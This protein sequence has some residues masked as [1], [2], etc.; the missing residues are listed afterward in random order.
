MSD[1]LE[2]LQ[3]SVSPASDGFDCIVPSFRPD[4]VKEVDLV[5][6]V[7]RIVG[8][9][10]MPETLPHFASAGGDCA[11]GKF[12]SA[13]RRLFI[14]QGMNEAHSHTLGAVSAFDDPELEPYRVKL[15]SALS[16][17][18]SVLRLSLVPGLLI[19][20]ASNLRRHETD[21]RLFELGK[22]YRT[23][24][25]QKY[26][27]PR[28]AAGALTGVGIDFFTAK[29]VIE[30]ALTALHVKDV[31]FTR[32]ALHGCHP[33]RCASIS[34]NGS[35]IGF[36][37]EIDPD[38]AKLHLDLPSSASRIAVF[39]IDADAL[40]QEAAKI[41]EVIYIAPPKFP[42]VSRDL[43]LTYRVETLYGEIEQTARTAVGEFLES[44][45]L[46]SVY[47]GDKMPE[48]F[49]SVAIR[50]TLRAE[51]RTLTDA[52]ADSVLSNV[53]EALTNRLGGAVR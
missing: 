12:E 52:D 34:V 26:S 13:L 42:A 14:A 32:S 8:Y 29:G 19:A 35:S 31:V 45:S 23:F 40:L 28:R 4:V 50:L 47:T 10:N 36:V 33:G 25:S 18:L 24:G 53:H 5:E 6:E 17:D 51:N 1:A 9:E 21:I 2:S 20:L 3:I 22:T 16:S 41:G 39:E 11:K 44:V 48:G 38:F 7:G 15:R 27:E 37:A 49:K 46:L 43:S 30:N